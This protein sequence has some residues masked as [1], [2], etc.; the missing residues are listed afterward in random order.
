MSKGHK[1]QDNGKDRRSRFD[2]GREIAWSIEDISEKLAR[3]IV[4]KKLPLLYLTGSE[5]CVKQGSHILQLRSVVSEPDVVLSTNHVSHM[6]DWSRTVNRRSLL[7]Q[8]LDSLVTVHNNGVW[9]KH[10]NRD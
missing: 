7:K 8:V 4:D 10:S 2:Q 1:F 5:G 3:D 6:Q 9:G